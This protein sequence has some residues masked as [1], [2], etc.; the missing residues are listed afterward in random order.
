MCFLEVFFGHA[1]VIMHY[2]ILVAQIWWKTSIQM[3][4]KLRSKILVVAKDEDVGL[5]V[6]HEGF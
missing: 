4:R 2:D 5:F 6:Q 1:A 3:A